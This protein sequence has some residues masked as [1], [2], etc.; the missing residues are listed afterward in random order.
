MTESPRPSIATESLSTPREWDAATYDEVAVPHRRW[1]VTIAERVSLS[2]DELVVDAGAGTGRLTEVVLERLPSGRI[3]AVDGSRQMLDKLRQR[4]PDERIEAVHGDL[5]DPLPVTGADA[6]VS[7]ATFHWIHDHDRLFANL[8][9]ALRPG[10][11]LV[12]QCGASGNIA[13]VQS[14]LVRV[15]GERAESSWHY[16]TVDETIGRLD[17]SGFVDAEVWTNDDPLRLER[18]SGLEAYLRTVVLG[19]ELE[20]V[21]ESDRDEFVASVAAAMDEPV[22]DYV[23]LNLV[24]R[25][26]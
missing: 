2:G 11:Q 4:L 23:R 21:A 10:G 7:S 3:L 24:A 17:A 9:T 26:R 12:A 5:L 1:A 14:A 8:A 22:V 16:A 15:R 18:G 6:I 20:T 19:G 13:G 25:R